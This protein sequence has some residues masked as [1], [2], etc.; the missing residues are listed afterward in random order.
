MT[1]F[2]PGGL[3]LFLT[4]I[5]AVIAGVVSISGAHLLTRLGYGEYETTVTV[6]LGILIAVW[7]C[8]SLLITPSMLTILAATLAMAGAFIVTRDITAASYG[9]ILGV[10]LLFVV[11]TAASSLG[12]YTGVSHTGRPQGLISKHFYL[13]YAAGLFTC[14]AVCGKVVQIF[15]LRRS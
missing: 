2:D 15:I 1:N 4:V 6:I 5:P 9:W 7:I 3:L 14:G 10:L 11:F 12:I 8:A 13:F